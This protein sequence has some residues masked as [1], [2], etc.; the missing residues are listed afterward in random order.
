M[1]ELEDQPRGPECPRIERAQERDTAGRASFKL[2][3]TAKRKPR[4][5][6][7]I[8]LRRPGGLPRSR[9]GTAQVMPLTVAQTRPHCGVRLVGL[10]LTILVTTVT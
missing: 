6:A 7:G 8:P 1:S 3:C 4:P 2:S 9:A 5:G 10:L